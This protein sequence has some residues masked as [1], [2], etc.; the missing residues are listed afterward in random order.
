M[1]AA[2]IAAGLF[3]LKVLRTYRHDVSTVTRQ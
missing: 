3:L 2:P 1:L